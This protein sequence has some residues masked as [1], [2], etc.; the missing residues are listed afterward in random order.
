[1]TYQYRISLD[2]LKQ[3]TPVVD[4]TNSIQNI[5]IDP[6]PILEDISIII[7][8]LGRPILEQCLYWIAAGSAWPANLIVIDQ[9]SNEDVKAWIQYLLGLG[10]NI[11]H[12][13]VKPQGRK[14][15][16][17][18]LG[19]KLVTTRFFTIT[20]DDCFVDAN[21]LVNM[22]KNLRQYG[23][24]VVTGRVETNG[25]DIV[26]EVSSSIPAVYRK[27]RLKFDSMSGGNMGTSMTVIEIAGAFD[28]DPCL[29]NAEDAE[30]S[31][32]VLRKGVPIV[33][34][35]DVCVRHVGWRDPAKR[36]EQY[37]NYAISHGGFYGKYI[38]KGDFF[39]LVRAVFHHARAFRRWLFGKVKGDQESALLGK[40]YFTNLFR[41]IL[42]GFRSPSGVVDPNG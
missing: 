14:S 26:N 3:R 37:T 41:G 11:H 8:T 31:Y 22:S 25:D 30:W 27:P 28:I 32:R 29:K 42:A 9:G 15:P 12:Y 34:A 20:D 13:P 2:E 24:S 10:L 1:L 4:Q 21:W 16:A 5:K 36:V 35:P 33:Y 40:I 38:R 7:P 19:L 39:I 17:I 18:N 23:D 6:R